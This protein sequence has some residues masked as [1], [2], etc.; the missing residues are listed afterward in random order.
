MR[1]ETG[2]ATLPSH[3]ASGDCIIV[4]RPNP[5]TE[6]QRVSRAIAMAANPLV[7]S[8][9]DASAK[10]T[11]RPRCVS[12]LL[13]LRLLFLHALSEPARM[14]L[15][16]VES[17][18]V[19]LAPQNRRRLGI[20]ETWMTDPEERAR[21][22]RR[23]WS[24][25][26]ALVEAIR[27]GVHV[28]HDHL[29]RVDFDTGEVDPCPRG[30]SAMDLSADEVHT[31]IVQASFPRDFRRSSCLASDGTD[32]ESYARPYAHGER[33]ADG[34]VCADPDARWGKR[35]PTDRRP[36]EHYVGYELHLS[37]Y[38]AA[39]GEQEGPRVCA[40]MVLRPGIRDRHDAA[41]SLIRAIRSFGPITEA[42]FD[43]GYTTGKASNF[44]TPMRDLGI[45]VT[46]DLHTSQRGIH[47]G[48]IP[49]TFWLDGHLYSEAMP[50]GLRELQPPRIGDT[51][52]AKARIRDQF[53]ARE[54]YRFTPHSRHDD[55]FGKQRFKGPAL[56][57]HLR[58]PNIPAS[59]R[60]GAH[61]PTTT[62]TP[63]E[64]CAC[65]ITIM[66]SDT[67]HER[68]RQHLPWQSSTWQ[69]SY[70]RRT[71]I[72]TLNSNIRFNDANVNRG[73]IQVFNRHATALLLAI[74]LAAFNTLEL[75]RW[76]TR[77][78]ERDPWASE[79]NEPTDKRPLGRFT[80]SARRHHR[81]P[82][83]QTETPSTT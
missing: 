71:Y 72:E 35:T 47:P 68:D 27:H 54:A 25:F 49:G 20:P 6:K 70:N 74:Y 23:I 4:Y 8:I 12:L 79:L 73:F 24:A 33:R 41:R 53:D 55:A 81:G 78:G 77:R 60:L 14:T 65:G 31:T 16:S 7:Q 42:L 22:Y 62:C 43:R 64:P 44:A 76:H 18:I 26:T 2:R 11:G 52:G 56:A 30:C 61:L 38:V 19:K 13:L 59:M 66:I 58:C 10:T 15:A 17:T 51:R 48:R 36:N 21:L 34:Q 1:T 45:A 57:G 37:T 5:L 28:D 46:M 29:L 40:G 63:G 82:P 69:E 9:V 80:R 39:V 50:A 32:L 67:E 3:T 75:H 83:G